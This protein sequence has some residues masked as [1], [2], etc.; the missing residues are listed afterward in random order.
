MDFQSPR[1]VHSDTVQENSCTLATHSQL[2]GKNTG[3]WDDLCVIGPPGYLWKVP[4]IQ[5]VIKTSNATVVNMHLC[6]FRFK[7]NANEP[8]PSRAYLQ[9]AITAQVSGRQWQCNCR[10]PIQEH[11]LDWY[12]RG[13]PLAQW[14]KKVTLQLIEEVIQHLY[15][16][17]VRA[18]S[19]NLNSGD[20][21][22]PKGTHWHSHIIKDNKTPPCPTTPLWQTNF[23]SSSSSS[24]VIN[25]AG[26]TSY[27]SDTALPTEA[28]I[29][30]EAQPSKLK[31]LGLKPTKRQK[32]IELGYED[33]GDDISGLGKDIIILMHDVTR[34]DVESSDDYFIYF[35]YCSCIYQRF[36]H[37]RLQRCCTPLLRQAQRS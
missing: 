19:A 4:N 34:E 5:E 6:H 20:V 15:V 12:V 22:D 25:A 13:E 35:H 11:F 28:R 36:P 32:V 23:S 33:C 18:L 10:V 21:R 37:Q 29:R 16:P 27:L 8:K 31:E 9:L 3:A 14:R 1:L 26:S 30:A 24:P 7:F 2:A 17:A